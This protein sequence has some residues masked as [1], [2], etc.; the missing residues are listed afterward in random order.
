MRLDGRRTARKAKQAGLSE[1]SGDDGFQE[2]YCIQRMCAAV[3]IY[4]IRTGFL[5][6][7]FVESVL[8]AEWTNKSGIFSDPLSLTDKQG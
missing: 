2:S 1:S 4:S 7:P 3:G 8:V 5:N 6:Q